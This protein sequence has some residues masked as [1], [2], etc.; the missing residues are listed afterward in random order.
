MKIRLHIELPDSAGFDWSCDE[1]TVE[2][3]RDPACRLSFP[4]GAASVISSRHARLELSS[5]GLC[6]RDMNSANGTFVNG[7]AVHGSRLLQPNDRIQL[8]KTGPVVIVLWFDQPHV[9]AAAF[10]APVIQPVPS[11][12]M[13]APLPA[14]SP[15]PSAWQMTPLS[16]VLL[17]I[18]AAAV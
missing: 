7:A 3:G 9:A 6:I 16:A 11:N 5:H 1:S 13:V 18:S 17:S 10:S 15:A 14:A 2:I 12:P 8:G 4:T